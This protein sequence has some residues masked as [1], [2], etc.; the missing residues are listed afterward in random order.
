M[1]KSLFIIVLLI[2]FQSIFSKD[3]IIK[4]LRVYSE[5]ETSFPILTP[6]EETNKKITIEFDIASETLPNLSIVFVTE[7]G[8]LMKIFF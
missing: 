5:T 6:L 1:K 2:S 3:I 8:I 4:S 7:I